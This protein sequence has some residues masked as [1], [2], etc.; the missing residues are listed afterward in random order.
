MQTTIGTDLY[1]A[2]ELLRSGELVGMPTETVYGLAGNALN[3][4]AVA[5]IFAVKERPSFDPLI[6]H[7]PD[8]AA[9]DRYVT[10]V[11][12]AA[13]RLAE[14]FWPGP[15]TMVFPRRKNVPDL[16]TAG[17]DTVAVRVP[18]HDLARSLLA[19]LDFPLAAPSA[20]PFGYIS[21]TSAAHVAQQL[22]GK[23]P[24]V[25]DGGQCRVGLESTIVSFAD[26]T[27][28]VLRKGGIALEE[29]FEALGGEVPVKTHS[30]SNPEAPGMLAR[31]YSPGVP[32]YLAGDPGIPPAAELARIVFGEPNAPEKG[33][34]S[35]SETGNNS[36]A[37]RN[38]FGL[39]RQLDAADYQG[40]VANLLPESGLGR[41]VNDRLRRAAAQE[42]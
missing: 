38:L 37:A 21:P 23:I 42:K 11:P 30:S 31:H 29:L 16:V 8:L 20:N 27:P 32:F 9:V 4:T 2:A 15:L 6:M 10:N 13:R 3:E 36:E 28:V 25:L 12:A 34:Y 40:I 5:K 24:Y 33:T 14:G 19:A 41:A 17:L 26:G 22:G 1:Q 39:L 18:Q 7:L 35:L